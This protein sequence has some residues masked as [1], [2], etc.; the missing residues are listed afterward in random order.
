L[1]YSNLVDDL[2]GAPGVLTMR[3]CQNHK[4][5]TVCL[6]PGPTE[7]ELSAYYANYY[8]HDQ[9]VAATNGK[10][11]LAAWLRL[12]SGIQR[13]SDRL[14]SMYPQSV[15]S[16][17]FLDVGCGN[18]DSLL[19]LKVLGWQVEEQEIDPKAQ[20]VAS[21]RGLHVHLGKLEQLRLESESYDAILINHVIE[22]VR[23]TEVLLVK[24]RRILVD[25]GL[26]VMTTPNAG[27]LGHRLFGKKWRGLEP[28]RH[29]QVFTMDSLARICNNAGFTHVG[30]K[31]DPANAV[32][33][34][35]ASLLLRFRRL[36][37][38][39]FSGPVRILSFGLDLFAFVVHF[40]KPSSGE[41]L[42]L[43]A[44]R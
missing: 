23:D 43:F 44:R 30:K 1:L 37:S 31:T 5:G 27:S 39:L 20:S 15:R 19:W 38:S 22:H 12:I 11:P 40:L 4:C 2:F 10:N 7:E 42:V 21:S 26:L 14:Y 41:E 8:T 33:I 35:Q 9:S 29:L 25:N 24:C 3:Q 6:G 28:P 18:G 34:P 32:D 13:Q 16:G 17:R 36:N